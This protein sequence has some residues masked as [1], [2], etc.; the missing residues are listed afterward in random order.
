M[1]KRGKQTCIAKIC[2]GSIDDVAPDR[3]TGHMTQ[4]NSPSTKRTE[5]LRALS[6]KDFVWLRERE[7]EYK[8]LLDYLH[9]H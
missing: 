6:E 1:P 3:Y 2:E 9:D 7:I 5:A 4:S 8:Q